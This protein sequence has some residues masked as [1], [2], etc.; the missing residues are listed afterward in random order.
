MSR[1]EVISSRQFCFRMKLRNISGAG[2]RSRC[3]LVVGYVDDDF[4]FCFS[5]DA[6]PTPH[7]SATTRTK[8][9]RVVAKEEP[10]SVRT[11]LLTTESSGPRCSPMASMPASGEVHHVSQE[12]RSVYRSPLQSF[13][14]FCSFSH[15]D[16]CM[17][18]AKS[19]FQTIKV[20]RLG[21]TT[22]LSS[23]V[24]LL[25]SAPRI[26]TTPIIGRRD[27]TG[28]A[29]KKLSGERMFRTGLGEMS[30]V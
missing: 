30:P 5:G 13:A 19:R 17:Y 28:G 26:G 25:V 22:R 24:Y 27:R 14:F 12:I 20:R 29:F 4:D 18:H 8:S 21:C 16:T 3:N 11:S 9:N 6:I 1:T 7:F 15:R 23:P 10:S 2:C